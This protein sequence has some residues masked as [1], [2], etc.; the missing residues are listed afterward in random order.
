EPE[1]RAP[2]KRRDVLA[3]QRR[4]VKV[5][6]VVQNDDPVAAREPAA[7]EVGADETRSPRDE[8]LQG[9]GT[10]VGVG[11]GVGAGTS[12]AGSASSAASVSPATG[13][14]GF[15][16]SVYRFRI[17][18]LCRFLI[19]Q[20]SSADSSMPTTRWLAASKIAGSLI[21]FPTVPWP[22]SSLRAMESRRFERSRRLPVNS[23]PNRSS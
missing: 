14:R 13:F 8:E 10:G 4:V 15:C 6:E 16:A 21:S 19:S 12:G 20:R 22:L 18:D 17:P 9:L 5:V 7:G 2:E 23:R 11:V 1:V 3:L